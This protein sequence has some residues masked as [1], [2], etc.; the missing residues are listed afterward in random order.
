M[1]AVSSFTPWGHCLGDNV[2]S[3]S[4]GVLLAA[5]FRYL[6][7]GGGCRGGGLGQAVKS[8][9]GGPGR[10]CSDSS[11]GQGCRSDRI[12]WRPCPAW[13]AW[14]SARCDAWPWGRCGCRS[15]G[16]GKHWCVPLRRSCSMMVGE[17][18]CNGF[19]P[20]SR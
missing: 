17:G 9:G 7:G 3:S 14:L 10:R 12:E 8:R 5:L 13:A 20:V 1:A 4:D 18:V 16:S 11:M 6:G 2:L 15:G 19:W